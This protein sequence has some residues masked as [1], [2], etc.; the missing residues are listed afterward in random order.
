MYCLGVGTILESVTIGLIMSF[1]ILILGTCYNKFIE[2][3]EL[4]ERFGPEYKEY[5]EKTPFLIPIF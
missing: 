1:L 2:E 3:K 5:K 4:R